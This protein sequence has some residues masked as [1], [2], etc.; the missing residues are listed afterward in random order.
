[1]MKKNQ[2]G[3]ALIEFVLILPV[4]ILLIFGFIDLG[5]IVLENNR[6]ESVT[7]MVINKYKETKDY[8]AVVQCIEDLGYKNIDIT[9]KREDN[10]LKVTLNKKINIMTP[11]LDSIL[12]DPYS[13]DVERVVNY[14]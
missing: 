2:K 14:E 7:T 10:V 13:L 8:N 12:S 9:I 4:I 5:R 6:L 3:Q 1:M 11:G